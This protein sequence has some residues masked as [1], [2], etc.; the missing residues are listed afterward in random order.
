MKLYMKGQQSII[1]AVVS[2]MNEF[3][4]QVVLKKACEVD[5]YGEC[6][7]G[8]IMKPDTLRVGTTLEKEFL[9]LARNKDVKFECGWH[10]VKNLNLGAGEGE[11]KDRD[12]EESLFF[13][14][15]NFKSL[16]S[17]NI[18]I[19]SLCH[20]LSQVLFDQV[21]AELPKLIEDIQCGIATTQA[22]LEKLGSNY[23]TAEKQ[24][25]FLIKISQKYQILYKNAIN[26]QYNNTFFKD[27]LSAK[28][29][30]C[31]VIANSHDDFETSLR[32]N[33]AQWIISESKGGKLVRKISS[34]KYH[35]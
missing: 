2:A 1:L 23:V 29:C 16:P 13:Q 33:G 22:E 35:T 10:V 34:S 11:I 20:C 3:A 7:I 15:S 26:D 25:A 5:S 8:I 12:S 17:C 31:A 27:H 4:N 19:S 9:A 18:G 32:E 30:L 6:T 21:R 14:K 28:R 24:K